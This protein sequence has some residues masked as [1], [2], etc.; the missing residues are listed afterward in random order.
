MSF[1]AEEVARRGPVDRLSQ[2]RNGHQNG[3]QFYRSASTPLL[4]RRTLRELAHGSGLVALRFAL[5]KKRM[6][7]C[8]YRLITRGSRG[9]GFY[10]VDTKTGKRASLGVADR[11]TAEQIVLAKNQALRQPALNLQIAKVY[12]A[13]SDSGAATRTWAQALESLVAAKME[14]TRQRWRT[15][16]KDRALVPILPKVI[17]ET[18]GDELL[19]VLQRGTVSTYVHLRKLHNLRNRHGWDRIKR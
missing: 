1:S 12:L 17:I 13:G 14:I 10:V 15:A 6:K 7:K 18:H 9:D 2:T 8:R 5:T 19:A 4:P 3:H 16:A 11:D